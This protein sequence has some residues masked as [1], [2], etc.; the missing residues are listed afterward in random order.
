MKSVIR[1]R[2]TSKPPRLGFKNSYMTT[3]YGNDH[4]TNYN[5]NDWFFT[6]GF[7]MKEDSLSLQPSKTPVT[8]LLWKNKKLNF[9]E[10]CLIDTLV[11][12][13]K[14]KQDLLTPSFKI[15]VRTGFESRLFRHCSITFV[16]K[17]MRNNFVWV[18]YT[19]HNIFP[20]EIWDQFRFSIRT[21]GVQPL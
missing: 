3:N 2:S 4:V 9:L 14:I 12:L 21:L 20:P 5:V 18:F 13:S 1:H 17:G 7:V 16:A 8:L 10:D 19:T 15:P 6:V 11:S